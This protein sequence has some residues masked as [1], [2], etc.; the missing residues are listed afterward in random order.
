MVRT[1]LIGFGLIM[2]I[3]GLA[4]LF[5]T[6]PHFVSSFSEPGQSMASPPT[7]LTVIG[8]ISV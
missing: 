6:H 4:D 5:Q 1:L 7:A 2:F 8:I 3:F